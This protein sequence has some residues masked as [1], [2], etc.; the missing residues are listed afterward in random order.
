M[1]KFCNSL[2][3]DAVEIINFKKYEV[4]NKRNYVKMQKFAILVK[5]NLN[6][7]KIKSIVKS[8]TIVVIHGNIEVLHLAYVI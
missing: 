3:K 5:K 7:L 1:N 8:G 4:I 6:M 2:R